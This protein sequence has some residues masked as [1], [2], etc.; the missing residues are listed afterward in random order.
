MS[1]S[2]PGYREFSRQEYYSGLPFPSPGDLP[3]PGIKSRCPALQADSLLL[4]HQGSPLRYLVFF[5]SQS[6]FDIQTTCPL[7]QTYI[8][9]PQSSFLR[10][11]WDTLSWD[12]SPNSFRSWI[13]SKSTHPRSRPRSTCS[14]LRVSS[15]L[16]GG[17]LA[18]DLKWMGASHTHCVQRWRRDTCLPLLSY[19][20]ITPKG[21]HQ[22]SP[23]LQI[24]SRLSAPG[25]AEFRGCTSSSLRGPTELSSQATR[26]QVEES[27]TFL[28][29]PA[30]VFF[31]KYSS[32]NP[33]YLC[34]LLR[35]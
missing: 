29:L 9:P 35:L 34:T 10:V 27:L 19:S 30:G 1:C 6:P 12:W 28:H 17:P 23:D 11:T 15:S 2:L 7:L 4:S 22:L 8:Q 31:K 33:L 16:Q 3:D 20:V 32:K 14:P 24:A 25:P 13:F 26:V 21:S 18:Q 5:N